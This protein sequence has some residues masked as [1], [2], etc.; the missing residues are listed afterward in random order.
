MPHTA[1][2]FTMRPL[3][4]ERPINSAWRLT[5]PT[6]S[7][8]GCTIRNLRLFRGCRGWGSASGYLAEA[9]GRLMGSFTTRSENFVEFSW[10]LSAT[11]D[12]SRVRGLRLEKVMFLCSCREICILKITFLTYYEQWMIWCKILSTHNK[13]EGVPLLIGK[14]LGPNDSLLLGNVKW[15]EMYCKRWK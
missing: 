6:V 9:L 2:A 13:S 11:K 1:A 12:G 5:L 15:W 10:R 4:V 7:L 3:V 8:W 14:T